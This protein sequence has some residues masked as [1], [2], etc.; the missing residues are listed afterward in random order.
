MPHSPELD[1]PLDSLDPRLLYMMERLL[2]WSK[3]LTVALL[4]STFF[5]P[6]LPLIFFASLNRREVVRALHKA[7]PQLRA[8]AAT[9]TSSPAEHTASA[10]PGDPRMVILAHFATLDRYLLRLGLGAI[11]LLFSLMSFFGMLFLS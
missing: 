4:V 5:P 9:Q 2:L 6:F 1:S 3:F 7:N 8:L 10:S 11:L